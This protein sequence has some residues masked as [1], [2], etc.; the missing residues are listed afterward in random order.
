MDRFTSFSERLARRQLL[1]WG[2]GRSWLDPRAGAAALHRWREWRTWRRRDDPDHAWHCCRLWPRTLLNKW[3]AREFA[4][5]H[6]A[7]L[8]ELYWHG[9][10]AEVPLERLPADFV[11]RP[12]RGMARHGV[13]AV[14][15][16]R[17]V[18]RCCPASAADLRAHLRRLPRPNRGLPVLV[19]EFVRTPEGACELPLEVKCF[20][21][22][23]VVGAIK[24][25]ERGDSPQSEGRSRYY[26]PDW[27]PIDD[28]IDFHYPQGEVR[29]PPADVETMLSLASR[30]GAAIGTF[31][32]VDFFLT[33]R[34]WVFNEFSSTPFGG[35]K[36]FT[37]VG[38]RLF[39][40][41]WDAHMP[42][43]S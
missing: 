41:L 13:C 37:P 27:Q 36:G 23:D 16:G 10:P 26:T 30:M 19:E 33:D 2:G 22:A 32:R 11:I 20:T 29:P 14:T 43:S 31:M 38:D 5:R 15:G 4:A 35:Q 12:V 21:F 9:D 6:G 18:M 39:G 1:W 7:A 24:V 40:S 17:D 42:D 3:N 25:I 8:A 28:R 34:G